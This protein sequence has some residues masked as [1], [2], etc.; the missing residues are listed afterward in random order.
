EIDLSW[1]A[2]T[3]N[4]GVTGYLLERCS[5]SNC[6]NFTQIATPPGTSFKDTGLSASTSYTYRVRATDAA[7]NLS[8]Y[9]GTTSASTFAASSGLVAAYGFDEGSG[10]TVSDAS[11]SGNNGTIA[12]ATWATAGKYAGGLQFNGTSARVTIPDA[13]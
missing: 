3:D 11:G 7:G 5:G 2:S 10:T 4:V 13:A 6:S 1:A 12:N 9:S 8:Q